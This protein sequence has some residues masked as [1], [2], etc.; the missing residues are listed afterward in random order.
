[1]ISE[2]LIKAIRKIAK[3]VNDADKLRG[4]PNPTSK[5]TRPINKF[6]SYLKKNK[7]IF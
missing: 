4:I 1:M 5:V 3:T 2:G 6:T 7:D